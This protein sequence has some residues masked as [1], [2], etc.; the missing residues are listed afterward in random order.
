MSY[1]SSET[2]KRPH[3]AIRPRILIACALHPRQISLSSIARC[4]PRYSDNAAPYQPQPSSS[5]SQPTKS[6]PTQPAKRYHKEEEADSSNG[7]FIL[8]GLSLM[9]LSFPWL[10]SHPESLLVVPLL[11]L[12]FAG[13][14]LKSASGKQQQ[15]RAAGRDEV[16]ASFS[17]E[18]S[19]PFISDTAERQYWPS[20]CTENR[21][22]VQ[23]QPV[24][25]EDFAPPS[26]TASPRFRARSR[27]YRAT[28][29]DQDQQPE[30]SPA[31]ASKSGEGGSHGGSRWKRS[32]VAVAP[33]MK[34]WGGFL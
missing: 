32:V 21:Y 28:S 4:S 6:M 24:A 22:R 3:A 30:S 27:P 11:F 33:F 15:V 8:I 13:S 29:Q 26:D 14:I 16:R 34:D 7:I 17:S 1:I 19:L 12:P 31:S 9:L 10:W 18:P 20:E 23:L 25:I 5:H 2:L